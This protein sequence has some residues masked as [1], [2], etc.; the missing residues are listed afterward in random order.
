MGL[1]LVGTSSFSSTLK[2][3]Q[4]APHPPEPGP[5]LVQLKYYHVSRVGLNDWWVLIRYPVLITYL[6]FKQKSSGPGLKESLVLLH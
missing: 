5:L 6:H 3:T 4:L 2:L 1:Y